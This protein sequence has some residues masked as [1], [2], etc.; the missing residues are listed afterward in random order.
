MDL[1]CHCIEPIVSN[2]KLHFRVNDVDIFGGVNINIRAACD[3]VTNHIDIYQNQT[4]ESSYHIKAR[5][6]DNFILVRCKPRKRAT[7]ITS[8][9]I[10]FTIFPNSGHVNVCGVRDFDVVRN[11][12]VLFNRI[13]K[14]T[15]ELNSVT[16]DN[17]TSSG[18]LLCHALGKNT[19]RLNLAGLK[20]FIQQDSEC[21]ERGLQLSLRPHFFPGGVLR[22][23]KGKCSILL[24]ATCKYVIVGAKTQSEITR[25]HRLTCALTR[26]W[27]RTTTLETSSA[28]TAAW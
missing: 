13:F 16:I 1:N 8:K 24:F 12:L 4:T 20:R 27:S 9:A 22:Q 2:V 15:L 11:V 14:T 5:L 23:G 3:I 25:A 18:K 21:I 28:P 7:S 19:K 17:S 6:C 26:R 10:V